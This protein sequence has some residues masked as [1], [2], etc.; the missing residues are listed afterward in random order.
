MG[1]VAGAKT[2]TSGAG[3]FKLSPEAK[4][5]SK[6]EAAARKKGKGDAAM[7]KNATGKKVAKKSTKGK[8]V[9]KKSVKGKKAG[10]KPAQVNK[11]G[12]K[13]PSVNTCCSIHRSGVSSTLR[14]S[15]FLQSDVAAFSPAVPYN[16]VVS[17][18]FISAISPQLDSVVQSNVGVKVTA[19]IDTTTISSPSTGID[20]NSQGPH[21][22]QMGHD[23]FLVI[24]GEGVV[25]GDTNN[26]CGVHEVVHAV[27][28]LCGAARSVRE[29]ILS[30]VSK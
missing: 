9:A 26:R 4:N 20:S 3:C 15:L 6:K 12:K 19:I 29:V 24:G 10:T 21:L 2:G 28:G 27:S 5:T 22:R 25:P 23:S 30:D 7:K 11:A 1:L 18:R 16:P 8:G 14:G 17:E 13:K